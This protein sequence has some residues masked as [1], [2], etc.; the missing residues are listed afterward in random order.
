[1]TG[2]STVDI[3]EEDDFKIAEVIAK[4]MAEVPEVNEQWFVTSDPA[5]TRYTDYMAEREAKET[6]DLVEFYST[7]TDVPSILMKDGVVHNDFEKPNM[8]IS[9]VQDIIDSMPKGI[10]W[11]KRVIN[12]ESNS[13]TLICQLPGEG[14]RR[15]FHKEWN[16]WWHIVQGEWIFEIEGARKLVKKG[17][18]VFIKKGR[19]HRIEAAG[20]EPAIRM[21][22]SRADVGHIYVEDPIDPELFKRMMR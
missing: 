8:E 9:N 20:N 1:M 13:M 21:A 16:E 7:E 10:S 19:V 15:H 3:D 18:V 17:D 5:D 2:F 11:S 14:N 4:S 6:E 12:T 22:V